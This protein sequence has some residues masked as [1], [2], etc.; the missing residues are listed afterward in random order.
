[1]YRLRFLRSIVNDILSGLDGNEKHSEFPVV[2]RSSC[3][4]SLSISL[5]LDTVDIDAEKTASFRFDLA[6]LSAIMRGLN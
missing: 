4:I 1:M 3:E 2:V 6:R 5:R